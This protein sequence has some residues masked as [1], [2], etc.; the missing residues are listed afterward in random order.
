MKIVLA[1]V[2][3]ASGAAA[4][5]P[6]AVVMEK[7]RPSV[8]RA[9]PV[10]PTVAPLVDAKLQ[11]TARKAPKTPK[12]V[13]PCEAPLVPTGQ[14]PRGMGETIRYVVDIDG[15][16]VGTVDFKIEKQGTYQGTP[17]TEYR[18]L[19]KID[20]LVSTFLPAEGRAAA[21]VPEKAFSP[22]MAMN[23]YKLSDA[24]FEESA[25]FSRNGFAVASQRKKNGQPKDDSREFPGAATDF[26]SGFYMLRSLPEEAN[27]CVI[28]YGNQRAYT[29]WLTPDGKE[30]VKTPVGYREA[31]RYK[32]IY[33]S[34]KSRTAATGAV[35][36]GALPERLPYKAELKGTNTLE[37]R[38]HMFEVGK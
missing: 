7:A 6:R 27:G 31:V 12:D 5:A 10:A 9:R 23:R 22:L 3:L 1:A 8:E 18:S 34:D 37:A 4:E 21:L 28:I 35:W 17:V 36:I 15:L 30:R 33:A 20:S 19:F 2:F 29:V 14:L 38:I 24:E 26:V 16:S 25:T 13:P 32:I 11:K